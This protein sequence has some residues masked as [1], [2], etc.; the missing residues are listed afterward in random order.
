MCT[1][2]STPKARLDRPSVTKLIHRSWRG[3][4]GEGI[5]KNGARSMTQI[6]PE[7]LVMVYLMNLRMLSLMIR[8]SSTAARCSVSAPKVSASRHGWRNGLSLID[9]AR[10]DC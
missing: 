3:S 8:P 5:P 10:S 4:N 2:G 7:L 6:S 9:C 1:A